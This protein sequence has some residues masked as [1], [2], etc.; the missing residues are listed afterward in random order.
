VAD[1]DYKTVS[2]RL[3]DAVMLKL[4]MAAHE[5]NVTLNDL[6]VAIM[7]DFI[8]R[9]R[10]VMLSRNRREGKYVGKHGG[11]HVRTK[12]RELQLSFLDRGVARA[13]K[14]DRLRNKVARRQERQKYL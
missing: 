3:D 6:T 14:L 11:N 5:T 2:I 1:D 8:Y 7:S 10:F 12:V 13:I 4:A 9:R